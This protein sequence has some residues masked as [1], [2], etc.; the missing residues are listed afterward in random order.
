MRVTDA[1]ADQADGIHE[2]DDIAPR[3]SPTDG[4]AKYGAELAA[5][6]RAKFFDLIV[7]IVPFISHEVAADLLLETLR[8]LPERLL[9]SRPL[10]AMAGRHFTD[11]RVIHS[12]RNEYEVFAA[13]LLDK[14][15]V[16]GLSRDQLFATVLFKHLH[17][18]DFERI[19]TGESL[20][21][22]VVDNIRTWVGSTVTKFEAIAAAED[23]IESSLAIDRRAEAAGERLLKRI[24]SS[25]FRLLFNQGAAQSV[26]VPGSKAFSRDEVVTREFWEALAA[27]ADQ[28]S[29]C[30]F[31][32]RRPRDRC[33]RCDDIP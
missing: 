30:A 12:I 32:P 25:V 31:Q 2:A 16:K 20:L 19:R 15:A 11:M 18:D 26:S 1:S 21:D 9:P 8:E 6:D 29:H 13:E 10:V 24:D 33:S 5:S 27:A 23:A 22:T 3:P 17:L 4:H 14:S 28:K 7:P